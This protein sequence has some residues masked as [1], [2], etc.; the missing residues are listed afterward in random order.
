MA[1]SQFPPVETA[2]ESGLLALGGDLEIQSL[3]LAYRNGIFPWPIS[4]DFPLAWFSPD[5]RGILE[6]DRLNINKRLRR[7]LKSCPYSITCNQA[8]DRVI[9]F[10]SKVPRSDQHSTWITRD[11]IK[12]YQNLFNHKLAYSI[13][14]WED[15]ELV[16]GVYGVCIHGIISGESMFHTQP[17]TSKFALIFLMLLLKRSGINWLDTQMV[18]PVVEALG[19]REI[20]RKDYIHLLRLNPLKTRDEIFPN[21]LEIEDLRELVTTIFEAPKADLS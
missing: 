16:G 13:E 6:F 9:E 15:T 2:D 10:C 14:V 3:I 4:D 17:N 19:G 21:Q 18:T 20:P 7:Y 8:F 1:I 12:G 5:P 11:I